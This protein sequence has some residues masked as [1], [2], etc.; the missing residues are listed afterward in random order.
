MDI[1]GKRVLVL[2]GWG[3]V[4]AAVC[5]RLFQEKPQLIVVASLKREEAEDAIQAYSR[6]NRAAGIGFA[7]AWGDIFVRHEFRELNREA[8]LQDT[9]KRFRLMHDCLDKLDDEILTSSSL[10]KLVEKHQPHLIIDCVNS[11]TGL[12]YQDIFTGS[13]RLLRELEDARGKAELTDS[14]QTEIERLL[15]CMTVPQLI[16]HIEILKATLYKFKV[17]GYFKIGTT[18]TGGMGLNIPYTH[19]EERPSRVLMSKSAMG[20]AHSLLLMLMSRTPLGT[21]IGEIKPAAAIA[22]KSIEY[23]SI[24]KGGKPIKL[25]DCPPDQGVELN[26]VFN[27]EMVCP[28][29]ETDQELKSVFIDTGE[30]GI[31]SYGEFAALAAIG[32]M[33]FVTPEEIAD[34]L[35]MEIKG[36]SS[37]YDVIAGLDSTVLG[38]SYRAGALMS[39][40]LKHM[41]QLQKKHNTDSVA[42]ELL[43]PPRL[44]KLLYE[45]YI[46]RQSVGAIND[47]LQAA[48]EELAGKAEKYI[49]ENSKIRS[50]ILSI[51]IPIL[52]PD[53]KTLLRGPVVKI[54]DSRVQKEHAISAAKID[55]W[56]EAGWVDLRAAN[57]KKWQKVLSELKAE[58]DGIPENDTSSAYHWNRTYWGTE[59]EILDPGKVVAWIFVNKEGDVG[60]MRIKR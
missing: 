2:G 19:S 38:P 8:I 29:S 37:G 59:E 36:N 7:A 1:T 21:G 42:F 50:Q 43:G 57:F 52:K 25:Y 5:H 56:A 51:G 60:G 3:L 15:S 39:G 28:C 6:D 24:R 34:Y 27:A 22:W 18:G 30:N 49:A 53:S 20:G 46:M 26:D 45:V 14:L 40:A 58:I 11:A 9:E 48:P 47:V 41:E 32:Q 35:A 17:Q 54:P 55:E 44:S 13:G 10:Y 23:G 16:R 4:G 12:A 31:F 33:E